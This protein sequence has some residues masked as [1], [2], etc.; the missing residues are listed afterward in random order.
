MGGY[1][2]ERAKEV[3][4][5]PTRYEPAAM[6]AI[7]YKGDPSVLPAEVAAWEKRERT[8]KDISEFLVSGRCK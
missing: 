8:R 4:V 6:M 1:D 5:I 3:L 2:H 7:G